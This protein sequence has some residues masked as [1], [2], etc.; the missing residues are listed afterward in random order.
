MC[1]DIYLFPYFT[2]YALFKQRPLLMN[3]VADI[4]G[5]CDGTTDALCLSSE[6]GLLSDL[7]IIP[8][9]KVQ[10]NMSFCRLRIPLIHIQPSIERCNKLVSILKQPPSLDQRIRRLLAYQLS[11]WKNGI[12]AGMF[13]SHASLL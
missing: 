1:N 7:V 6:L 4:E 8:C 12:G 11:V 10:K 9:Q 5:S 13:I 2:A 3:A